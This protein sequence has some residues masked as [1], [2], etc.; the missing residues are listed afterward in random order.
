MV[1][2][3][4]GRLLHF[5]ASLLRSKNTASLESRGRWLNRP[6]KTVDAARQV[7]CLHE[8]VG[9]DPVQPR[10]LLP[11]VGGRGAVEQVVELARIVLI[12][13]ELVGQAVARIESEVDCVGPV[14]FADGANAPAGRVHRQEEGVVEGKQGVAA[15]TL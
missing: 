1:A 9:Q 15:D 10:P 11:H 8:A 12:V 13:V 3:A 4:K 7:A 6:G 2:T 5:M 14:A